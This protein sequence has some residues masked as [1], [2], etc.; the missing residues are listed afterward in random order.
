[1]PRTRGSRPMVW[2]IQQLKDLESRGVGDRASQARELRVSLPQVDRIRRAARRNTVRRAPVPASQADPT[3]NVQFHV[4]LP[5]FVVDRLRRFAARRGVSMS[6]ATW[7]ALD[8]WLTSRGEKH[9]RGFAATL[10]DLE[11]L[12]GSEI[13]T[14]RRARKRARGEP[15]AGQN[16]PSRANIEKKNPSASR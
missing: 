6:L 14:A 9:Q 16:R 5:A 13:G 12:F 11:A 7:A 2:R 10:G 3:R 15:K 4:L 8:E 1:M